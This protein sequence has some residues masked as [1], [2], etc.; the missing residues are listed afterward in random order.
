VSK[1]PPNQPKS[2]GYWWW[3]PEPKQPWE[4]VKVVNHENPNIAL[5]RV[6]NYQVQ[7]GTYW[8]DCEWGEKVERNP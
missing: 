3:R 4:I 2:C 1:K 5:F 8:P 7:Y 6:G